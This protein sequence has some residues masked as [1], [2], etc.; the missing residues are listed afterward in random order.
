MC[1]GKKMK[2]PF[3]QFTVY[4]DGGFAQT[5]IKKCWASGRAKMRLRLTGPTF[6]DLKSHGF[7]D[8]LIAAAALNSF[9]QKWG[10]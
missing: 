6:T 10:R 1:N 7:Q 4:I 9:E 5:V 2:F 3:I 8:M